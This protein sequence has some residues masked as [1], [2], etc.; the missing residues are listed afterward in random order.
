MAS[1]QGD[2]HPHHYH[3]TG[4]LV[5]AL[6]AVGMAL[7]G[8]N[9]EKIQS[10]FV[11]T[12]PA[13]DGMLGDWGTMPVTLMEERRI[14][15]GVGNDLRYLY[16]AGR[17][18]DPDMIRSIERS[19]FTLWIDPGGRKSKNLEMRYPASRYASLDLSRGGFWDLM[20]DSERARAS[21]R[22]T[23][24][25][26][27][28]L[29]VDRELATSRVFSPD[30]SDGFRL[31]Y[32]DSNGVLSFEAQIPLDIEHYFEG[33]TSLTDPAS[34][35]IGFGSPASAAAGGFSPYRR[36][37][38]MMDPG[39]GTSRGRRGMTSTG[40]SQSSTE[41]LWVNLVLAKHS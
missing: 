20:T 39:R 29:V 22:L 33:E 24:R 32:V 36:D 26:N 6:V 14:S 30:S 10:T 37:G 21:T 4:V 11:D 18:A 12:P 41:D 5:V 7:G 19:G 34:I 9:D 17:M 38:G 1:R 23:A 40:R 16:L 27:G 3:I 13:I 28:V 2:C 8:C 31:A 25:R 15:L 35:Q